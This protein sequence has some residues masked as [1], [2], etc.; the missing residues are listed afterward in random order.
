[1][2]TAQIEFLLRE[3]KIPI[4]PGI[5]AAIENRD[6]G[7][8]PAEVASQVRERMAKGGAGDTVDLASSQVPRKLQ[9]D[10]VRLAEVAIISSARDLLELKRTATLALFGEF[11]ALGAGIPTTPEAALYAG[12][13]LQAKFK[14]RQQQ[15][16]RYG[17][18]YRLHQLLLEGDDQTRQAAVNPTAW[19]LFS[20]TQA[21]PPPSGNYKPPSIAAGEHDEPFA[22]ALPI[23]LEF[24]VSHADFW[25]PDATE[26]NDY[27]LKWCGEV[28]ESKASAEVLSVRT[29]TL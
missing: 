9:D 4:P 14:Q 26:C 23:R 6:K 18:L 17:R 27:Y 7:P 5:K 10:L 22:E 13:E 28:R 19:A 21:W 16:E 24:L 12:P 25:Q 2:R 29:V 11:R 15:A 20:D 3:L 1:M 8:D